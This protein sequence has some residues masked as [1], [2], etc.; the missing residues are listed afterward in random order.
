MLC[1]AIEV[2][3]DA[4]DVL[5]VCFT[6]GLVLVDFAVVGGTVKVELPTRT[7]VDGNLV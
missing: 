6:V 1:D 7:I 4:V 3:C 2:L 5:V